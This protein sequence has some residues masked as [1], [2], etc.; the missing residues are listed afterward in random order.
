[1][2][3]ARLDEVGLRQAEAGRPQPALEAPSYLVDHPMTQAAEETDEERPRTG[4]PPRGASTPPSFRR[5]GSDEISLHEGMD[6]EAQQEGGSLGEWLGQQQRQ[7]EDD[8]E[9]E[10]ESLYANRLPAGSSVGLGDGVATPA[11]LATPW[12]QGAVRQAERNLIAREQQEVGAEE[13]RVAGSASAVSHR[14]GSRP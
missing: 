1:M 13:V 5:R 3:G 12:D 6:V 4:T 2:L 14:D 10:A 9:E 11:G 8:L 7:G